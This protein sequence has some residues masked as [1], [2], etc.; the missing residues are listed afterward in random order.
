[1]ASLCYVTSCAQQHVTTTYAPNIQSPQS[2]RYSMSVMNTRECL[3]IEPQIIQ[4][5]SHCYIIIMKHEN[6]ENILLTIKS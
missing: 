3:H 5:K 4:T 6:I 2:A 1:M